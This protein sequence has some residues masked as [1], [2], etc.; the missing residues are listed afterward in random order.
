MKHKQKNSYWHS[1]KF[2]IFKKEKE[3]QIIKK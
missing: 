2:L 3:K 1:Y